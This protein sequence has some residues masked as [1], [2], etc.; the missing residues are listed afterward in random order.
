MDL[1]KLG[2]MTQGDLR[3]FVVNLLQSDPGALPGRL[4]HS[5]SLPSAPHSDGDVPVWDTASSRWLPSSQHPVAASSLAG[6]PSD[7]TK[8]L[9]GDGTWVT[10]VEVA[11]NFGYARYQGG[12]TY[13]ASDLNG[14]TYTPFGSSPLF[15][16][17]QHGSSVSSGTITVTA[18]YYLF[19]L[20]MFAFSAASAQVGAWPIYNGSTTDSVVGF[21]VQLIKGA[22]GPPE[23]SM[24][25]GGVSNFFSGAGGTIALQSFCSGGGTASAALS[26]LRLPSV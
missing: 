17:G 9:A 2:N 14:R 24:S 15:A 16:I 20:A 1:D 21:G 12:L 10:P 26:I 22:S 18:G 3:R 23:Q 11:S 19:C 6:Y 13:S 7:A 8:A 4:S 5:E 25:G